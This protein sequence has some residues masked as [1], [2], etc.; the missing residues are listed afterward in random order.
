[1]NFFNPQRIAAMLTGEYI[2]PECGSR[3]IFEDEWG[4]GFGMSALR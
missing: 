3:L 4:N 1:M 2:C